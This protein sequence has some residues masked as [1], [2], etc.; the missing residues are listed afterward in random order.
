MGAMARIDIDLQELL[1]VIDTMQADGYTLTELDSLDDLD[2]RAILLSRLTGLGW[3]TPT[4]RQAAR[5]SFDKGDGRR[6]LAILG[7]QQVV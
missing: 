5:D 1:A 6:L 3:I 7:G 2:A 4:E